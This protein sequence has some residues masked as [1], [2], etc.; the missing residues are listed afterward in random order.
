MGW[1]TSEND[2]NETPFYFAYGSNL[3][4]ARIEERLGSCTQAGIGWLFGYE[5]RFHKRSVDDSGKGNAAYTGDAAHQIYGALYRLNGG[6]KQCLDGFEGRGYRC[7]L[8]PICTSEGVR[9][10]WTY[11][12]RATKVDESLVPYDWYHQLVEC[13][14]RAVGLPDEYV[15][16]I[17]AVESKVDADVQRAGKNF[18]LLPNAAN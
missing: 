10:A 12:A 14:A 18:A 16:R 5:L 3:L 13:G 11:V 17:S 8:L 2:M 1:R 4:P 9:L 7:D 15:H 6:Q